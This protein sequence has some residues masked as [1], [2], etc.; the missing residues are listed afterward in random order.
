MLVGLGLKKV[1]EEGKGVFGGRGCRKECLKVVWWWRDFDSRRPV[2]F[3]EE[4]E[5][6]KKG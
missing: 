1:G 2:L 6:A 3:E 4:K 5:R